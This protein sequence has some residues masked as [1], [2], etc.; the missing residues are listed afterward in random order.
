MRYLIFFGVF[1]VGAGVLGALAT[2]RL[3]RIAAIA[4]G[5]VLTVGTIVLYVLNK[6]DSV[7][8][9]VPEKV[10]DTLPPLLTVSVAIGWWLGVAAMLGLR[11]LR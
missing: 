5:C 1:A 10:A 3:G 11:R 2:H 8:G 9:T 4:I 6:S 7:A